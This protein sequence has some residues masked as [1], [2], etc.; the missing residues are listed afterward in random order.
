VQVGVKERGLN[1]ERPIETDWQTNET[2]SGSGLGD[3]YEGAISMRQNQ[4]LRR[5]LIALVATIALVVGLI[6][7]ATAQSSGSRFNLNSPAAFPV[8]I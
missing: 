3:I 1:C 5:T 2:T 6:T 7:I 4:K 8:D